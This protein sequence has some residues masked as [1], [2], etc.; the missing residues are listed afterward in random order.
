MDS[1][2]SLPK[3]RQQSSSFALQLL[4]RL[5]VNQRDYLAAADMFKMKKTMRWKILLC[6]TFQSY[7][8]ILRCQKN[9]W[10]LHVSS[11]FLLK[12]QLRSWGNV[13]RS[14]LTFFWHDV[15]PKTSFL[16]RLSSPVVWAWGLALPGFC[17]WEVAYIMHPESSKRK[18][19][20]ILETATRGLSFCWVHLI[21]GNQ[22]S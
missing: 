9:L 22:P 20:R 13:S 4:L 14:L 11:R 19:R 12:M 6:A 3:L 18:S 10:T 8:N 15:E 21:P 5:Q 2:S 17:A 7:F 16:L 1:F